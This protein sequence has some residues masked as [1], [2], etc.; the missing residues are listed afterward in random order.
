[1]GVRNGQGRKKGDLFRSDLFFPGIDLS[2]CVGGLPQG[3]FTTGPGAKTHE[4]QRC[5]KQTQNTQI[6]FDLQHRIFAPCPFDPF[7]V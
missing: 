3:L 4:G 6:S 7:F 1:M 2:V 5:E